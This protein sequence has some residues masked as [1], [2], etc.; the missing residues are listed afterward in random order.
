MTRDLY[1]KMFLEIRKSSTFLLLVCVFCVA[2]VSAQDKRQEQIFLTESAAETLKPVTEFAKFRVDKTTN[3]P[4][5]VQLNEISEDNVSEVKSDGEIVDE[6]I[7]RLNPNRQREIGGFKYNFR[8][9]EKRKRQIDFKDAATID[10]KRFSFSPPINSSDDLKNAASPDDAADI[11]PQGFRWGSAIRQSLMFLAIQHGY[12]FTQPKT[13]EA[14]KGKFWKDYAKS[15]KSLHG[16]D[17][18]GRFFTNYIAHPM[19][20]SFVGFI[21]IQNDPKGLKQQ[22]GTS[23]DY[24][25]SR[26]KAM[27]WSAAWSVQFEI[28]PISQA[29]IGNVGLKGK[30]TWED[31]VVTP[32]LGTAMLIGEDAIDRFVMKRIERATDNF[33]IKIF[34]RMLLSPTRTIANLFRFKAPW[35]R[36]RP[37][38]Y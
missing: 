9:T 28:G 34:S 25:R 7:E 27:A 31:I 29:S 33:Y 17:D 4:H 38:E 20:G 11:K 32:T 3:V 1:K 16:W 37:R 36:D 23:G 26:L 19:Q 35:H 6:K 18:G 5:F 14:L 12:A 21:Q 2:N 15:V 13:R 30:Q 24:W 10:G 8:L 22:F